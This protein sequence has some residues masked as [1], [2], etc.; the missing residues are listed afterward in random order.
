[1]EAIE[2]KRL[3]KQYQ[4]NPKHHLQLHV[5]QPR[6]RRSSMESPWAPFPWHWY[7][8]QVEFESNLTKDQ[9]FSLLDSRLPSQPKTY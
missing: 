2:S 4:E 3:Y 1:M 8:P 9:A 6:L 5:P 7:D